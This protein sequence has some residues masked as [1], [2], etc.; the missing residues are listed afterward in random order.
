MVSLPCLFWGNHDAEAEAGVG[1]RSAGLTEVEG[2][3]GSLEMTQFLSRTVVHVLCDWMK[4]CAFRIMWSNS[5]GQQRPHQLGLSWIQCPQPTLGL[6]RSRDNSMD[7]R[8]RDCESVPSPQGHVDQVHLGTPGFGDLSEI[9]FYLP[10]TQ[11]LSFLAPGPEAVRKGP[12]PGAARVQLGGGGDL[13]LVFLW[14]LVHTASGAQVLG[15]LQRAH[16]PHPRIQAGYIGQYFCHLVKKI[17]I[18]PAPS[19]GHL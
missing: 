1:S 12:R 14:S 18:S 4:V 6:S 11:I 15:S 13:G 8:T 3:T 9:C 16:G 17:S 10:V 5:W 7:R 19:F 2:V